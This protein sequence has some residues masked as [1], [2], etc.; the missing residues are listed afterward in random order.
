[1]EV[2]VDVDKGQSAMLDA[3]KDEDKHN[4]K[5]LVIIVELVSVRPNFHH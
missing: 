3:N 5:L 2:V 1:M 4:D